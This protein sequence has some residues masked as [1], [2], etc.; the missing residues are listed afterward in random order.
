M[1]IQKRNSEQN[2][3]SN[4]NQNNNFNN[5]YDANRNHQYNNYQKGHIQQG[6]YGVPQSFYS[7]PPVYQQ[8]YTQPIQ[9]NIP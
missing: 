5:H 6:Y 2:L 8:T 9:Q 4:T 7:F 3:Q 1:A